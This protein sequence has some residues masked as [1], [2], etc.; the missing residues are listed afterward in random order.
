MNTNDPWVG[1]VDVWV[2]IQIY[3]QPIQIGNTT[4]FACWDFEKTPYYT[5]LVNHASDMWDWDLY[6][7]EDDQSR[8]QCHVYFRSEADLMAFKLTWVG[9]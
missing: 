8:I 7:I 3:E 6:G 4:T 2:Q 5:W 1:C 9:E